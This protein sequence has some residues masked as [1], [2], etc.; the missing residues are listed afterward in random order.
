MNRSGLLLVLAIAVATGLAFG[1][2]PEL[3]LALAGLFYDPARGGFWARFNEGLQAV[4]EWVSWLIALIVIL[5]IVAWITKLILPHR[6]MF[7]PGRAVVLVLV[8]FAF[9]PGLVANS[10]FKENWSRPRPI[11]IPQFGGVEPF[12]P[13]WDPRGACPKNCSFIAGEPSAAFWTLAPAA[14]APPP[15]RAAAY[16]GAIAFGAA[17]GVLRMAMGGH[18]ASDVI[19]A[20]IF[21]FL[22]IW[23]FYALI[24]RWKRT[25]F[26]DAAIERGIEA[27]ALPVQGWLARRFRRSA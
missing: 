15:W 14:L 11:D 27:V 12:K 21:M 24:Y 16:A 20:G 22:T 8:T 9:G 25:R 23:F 10:L 18:F 7:M 17:I 26:S 13:W 6:P 1:L 3:D 2:F 4:R 5:P 19:F